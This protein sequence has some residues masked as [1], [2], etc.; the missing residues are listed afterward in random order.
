M[1][2]WASQLEA[3]VADH[4]TLR[5][6]KGFICGANTRVHE[7]DCHLALGDPLALMVLAAYEKID[8]ASRE[9]GEPFPWSEIRR[10]AEAEARALPPEWREQLWMVGYARKSNT[11][12]KNDASSLP[13]AEAAGLLAASADLSKAQERAEHVG[14]L[15]QE[16]WRVRKKQG[17]GLLEQRALE[18]CLKMPTH[19]GKGKG[20]VGS[21][22][23]VDLLV[24]EDRFAPQK[25]YVAY[26]P[27][28]ESK[29]V[30]E[31]FW[32]STNQGGMD[33]GAAKMFESEVRARQ[34]FE[35]QGFASFAL[36][37]VSVKV[38][39]VAHRQ[40]VFAED[41]LASALARSEREAI[42]KALE[43]AN[44]EELRARLSALEAKASGQGEPGAVAKRGARL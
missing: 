12:V 20:F 35:R 28:D 44:I 34:Y 8:E 42:V 9:K 10:Q 32:G 5:K 16:M 26:L 39:A 27:S 18:L 24:E 31:G 14:K 6:T 19:F 2:A 13:E 1:E 33:L 38:E 30:S 40:G 36:V 4:G 3:L 22:Q 41:G 23:E 37:E 17:Y 15:C 25:A 21:G 29:G 7:P 43:M 11:V